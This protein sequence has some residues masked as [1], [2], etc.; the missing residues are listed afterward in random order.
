[1]TALVWIRSKWAAFKGRVQATWL[2]RVYGVCA[3]QRN[4]TQVMVALSV[5]SWYMVAMFGCG[6]LTPIL[7]LDQMHRTEG[8]LLSVSYSS[9]GKD[10]LRIRLDSGEERKY[11]GRVFRARDEVEKAI[12]QRIVVWSQQVYEA[13]PPF[14]YE[15]WQEAKLHEKLLFDYKDGASQKNARPTEIIFFKLYLFLATVPLLLVGWVCR[16][17]LIVQRNI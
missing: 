2:W 11:L 4:W 15:R 9:R 16:K 3:M 1:M 17:G 10:T 12:G 13:W 7:E 6:L 8:V 5:F 14:V